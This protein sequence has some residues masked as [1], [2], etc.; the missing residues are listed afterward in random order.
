MIQLLAQIR[1][2][3]EQQEGQEYSLYTFSNHYELLLKEYQ[4]KISTFAEEEK[5]YA[6]HCESEREKWLDDKENN[7]SQ[8]N[9]DKGSCGEPYGQ[10]CVVQTDREKFMCQLLMNWREHMAKML[11]YP[12]SKMLSFQE[13][14]TISVNRPTSLL[15]LQGMLD[16]AF[17][18]SDIASKIL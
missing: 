11:D 10:Q 8:N 5:E 6:G 13:I 16:L 1:Y 15:E 7:C 4:H 18:S 3:L 14:V 2:F 17:T 9:R 12:A